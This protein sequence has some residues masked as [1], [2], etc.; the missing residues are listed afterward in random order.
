MPAEPLHRQWAIPASL[1]R[2]HRP[3]SEGQPNLELTVGPLTATDQSHRLK[4]HLHLPVD[5][6][7]VYDSSGL[8]KT[9]K[10]A[11]LEQRQ[12]FTF[13][14]LGRGRQMTPLLSQHLMPPV[15]TVQNTE[16]TSLGPSRCGR[17]P[18]NTTCELSATDFTSPS[19]IQAG[20]QHPYHRF[21]LEI[22]SDVSVMD[23][24]TQAAAL[25]TIR[26]D[27]IALQTSCNPQIY[28][29]L[30]H[31]GRLRHLNIHSSRSPDTPVEVRILHSRARRLGAQIREE[32]HHEGSRDTEA[33][34]ILVKESLVHNFYHTI[35]FNLC[36]SYLAH[37]FFP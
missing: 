11:P 4:F 8:R 19:S 1:K 37:A 26:P 7:A 36:C 17:T 33:G 5:L 32:S 23:I 27:G 21:R 28:E 29:K 6:Q 15:R 24:E 31:A 22:L 3:P 35:P 30:L 18:S 20:K 25:F 2:Y 12:T 14:L 13:L 9:A 34:C 16:N 10:S